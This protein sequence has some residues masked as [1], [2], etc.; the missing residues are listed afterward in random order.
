MPDSKRHPVKEIHSLVLGILKS[1]PPHLLI[2]AH[3]MVTSTGWGNPALVPRGEVTDGLLELDYVVSAL[4]VT[5]AQV[6]LPVHAAYLYEGELAAVRQVKVHAETNAIL[7]PVNGARPVDAADTLLG[8]GPES[9]RSRAV[10]VTALPQTVRDLIGFR[11]RVIRRDERVATD[12]DPQRVSF[13]VDDA[14]LISK[15]TVG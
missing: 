9:P 10:S 5:L 14:G 15:I 7:Q 6:N 8:L 11:L 13:H 1:N 2:S 12:H 3:G 4:P